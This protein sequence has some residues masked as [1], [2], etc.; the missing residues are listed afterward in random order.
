MYDITAERILHLAPQARLSMAEALVPV[1]ESEMPK[2]GATTLLRRA[3]FMAQA[4]WETG[5]FKTFE[6]NLDYTHADA[7]ARAWPRLAGRSSELAGHPEALAN[8]AYA[9]KDGNGDEASGDG[10]RFRGR[11][12]FDITGRT[13]Y[14]AAG[15]ALL[16]DLLAEPDSVA[17]PEMAVRTALWFWKTRGCNEAADM[18][19]AERVTL[20]INGAALNALEQREELTQEAKRIF[21]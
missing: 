17:Q 8:A 4:C 19:D 18:D 2:W 16:A 3:H 1:L 12:C 13:N 5:Y 6:E 9:G 10:W 14:S 20:R 15:R 7:I 11:G 21:T